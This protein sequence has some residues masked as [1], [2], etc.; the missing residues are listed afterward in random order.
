MDAG[1]DAGRYTFA[2]NIPPDFQRDVLAGRQPDIQVNVDATRMSRAFTGNS[3]IQNIISGEVNS[4][5]A[6]YRDN[7]EPPVA[8]EMR[9]RF[10]LIWNPP[11]LAR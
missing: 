3:Y 1:L 11:A 9:M 4:F 2:V 8:L 5:V 6:R 10:N 7:N